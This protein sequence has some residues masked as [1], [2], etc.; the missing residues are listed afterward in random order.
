MQLVVGLRRLLGRCGGYSDHLPMHARSSGVRQIRPGH[1]Y[2]QQPVLVCQCHLQHLNGPY[3]PR[4][5][6]ASCVQ[7]EDPDLAESWSCLDLLRGH[8]VS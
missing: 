2:Q 3:H 5:A 4:H 6:H 1:L 7:V 8:L